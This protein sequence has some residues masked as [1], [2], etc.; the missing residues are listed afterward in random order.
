MSTRSHA[1]LAAAALTMTGL[2]AVPATGQAAPVAATSVAAGV[3]AAAPA[4]LRMK[5]F[6][7]PSKNIRCGMFKSGGKWSMR[8]DVYEHSWVAPG[9]NP[10]GGTGDYGSS[11]GMG[12]KG[13]PKFLCVSDAMDNGKTLTYGSTISYGPYF[14]RS[15]PK[16]LKCYN[17]RAHGWFLSKESYRFF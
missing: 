12:R 9:P 14:C 13:K 7:T 5:F 11:V 3:S 4:K 15:R 16:G 10:C 8:C 6:K 2:A 17:A 1:L